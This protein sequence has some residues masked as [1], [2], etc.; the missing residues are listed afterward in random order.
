MYNKVCTITLQIIL[1]NVCK[2]SYRDKNNQ[3]FHS[4]HHFWDYQL[5]KKKNA[6]R[7]EYDTYS[8]AW[9]SE[10][11]KI[12]ILKLSLKIIKNDTRI[13]ITNKN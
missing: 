9:K 11:N 8:G 10:I 2:N 4:T 7:E 13:N 6:E 5:C 3:L 1:Y 12:G